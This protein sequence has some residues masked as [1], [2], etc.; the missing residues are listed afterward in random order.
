ARVRDRAFGTGPVPATLAEPQVLAR[1]ARRA[2]VSITTAHAA[3]QLVDELDTASFSRT[4]EPAARASSELAKRV[5]RTYRAIDREAC[6]PRGVAFTAVVALLLAVA[7]GAHAATIDSDTALFARGVA[8]YQSHNFAAAERVF[9]DITARVPRAADAW[10]N[11]GTAAF[12]AGDTAGAALGWQRA[13]RIEPL[14]SD[15]RDRLEM[16]GAVSG[17][18]AVP[19]IPP[20]PIALVAAACWVLAWGALAWNLARRRAPAARVLVAGSLAIAIVLG[21][22]AA[23]V[24]ARLAARDLVLVIQDAPL[25]DLPA[26]ASDRTTTLRP[27]EIARVVE[28]QGP[29]VRVD[30]DGGR[31]GWAELDDLTSLS[32]D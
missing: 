17:L 32:R 31:H 15:V 21:A 14:A 30:T 8:A 28:R 23:S 7:G 10:A 22:V 29:W 2:G 13:L 25:H 27:G 1:A 16:L 20:T 26:L 4:G 18:G 11:L 12:S 19:A 6:R 9:A 5:E 3:A 24:D